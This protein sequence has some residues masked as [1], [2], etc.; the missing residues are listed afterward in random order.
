[1]SYEY[2]DNVVSSVRL[3]KLLVYEIG[4]LPEADS[5]LA[6]GRG[7]KDIEF[8]KWPYSISL[9]LVRVKPGE[10]CH[11]IFSLAVP[12]HHV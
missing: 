9:I 5:D 10:K 4:L 8:P 2:L 7:L 11:V 6:N 12:N 1:V 3:P